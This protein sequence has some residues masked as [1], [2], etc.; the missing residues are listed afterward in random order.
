MRYLCPIMMLRGVF[1]CFAKFSS[2]RSRG[3]KMWRSRLDV[4]A[5]CLLP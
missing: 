1:T 5:G 2:M 3:G 4:R